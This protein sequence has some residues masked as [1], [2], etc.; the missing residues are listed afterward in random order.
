ML[1]LFLLLIPSSSPEALQIND[2]DFLY[3]NQINVSP[4]GEPLIPL[5]IMDGQTHVTIINEKDVVLRYF[6]G[7]VYKELFVPPGSKIFIE[8][9]RSDKAEV[10]F[11]LTLEA[12][13]NPDSSG[14]VLDHKR[15]ERQ[16]DHYIEY[17]RAE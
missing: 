4:T 13:G 5:G 1:V 12:L 7:T 6:E 14:F 3:S 16:N 15:E 10:E 8:K 11:F 17:R 2:F 9:I